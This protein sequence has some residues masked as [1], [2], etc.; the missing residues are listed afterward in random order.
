MGWEGVEFNIPQ[1]KPR[2][3]HQKGKK[4]T[5]TARCSEGLRALYR[6]PWLTVLR[7]VI[8]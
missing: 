7:T 1:S 3:H 8:R 4:K 2:A 5:P 6:A